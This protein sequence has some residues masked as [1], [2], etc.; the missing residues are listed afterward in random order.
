MTLLEFVE[1]SLKDKTFVFTFIVGRID[2]AHAKDTFR[3]TKI[4]ISDYKIVIDSSIIRHIF[5]NHGNSEKETARKQIAVTKKDILKIP[6]IIL[7][8][9][10]IVKSDKKS[11]K[12]KL[13]VI[14]YIKQYNNKFY[15]L[16]EVR[17]GKKSIALCTMYIKKTLL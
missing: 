11:D 14:K 13:D 8:P 6:D 4:N 2:I 12:H 1:K 3:K 5:D 7:K 10:I 9:D 15:V 16:E 17:T